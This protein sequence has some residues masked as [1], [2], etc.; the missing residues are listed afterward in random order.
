MLTVE[1]PYASASRSSSPSSLALEH[2]EDHDVGVDDAIDDAVRADEDLAHVA[3]RELGHDASCVRNLRR[4]ARA[5]TESLD[6]RARGAWG[7]ERDVVADRE[8]VRGGA[9]P[10]CEPSTSSAWG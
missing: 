4:A 10:S 2:R 1:T 9:F 5:L 7:V 6:P 3:S 8:E